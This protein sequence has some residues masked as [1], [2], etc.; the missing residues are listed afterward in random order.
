MIAALFVAEDGPYVGRPGVDPWTES[1][2]ARLY[3]GT[4]PVVEH[5][6]CGTWGFAARAKG[7]VGN[8]GGCFAFAVETVRRV[9]G[10]IEHPRGSEAFKQFGLPIPP[11]GKRG[12]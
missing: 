1:R 11:A 5:P 8:D 6:P 7:K 12:W 9:G 2:D 4:A 10:V 3:T